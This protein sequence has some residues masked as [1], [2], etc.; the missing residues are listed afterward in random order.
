MR[1]LNLLSFKDT[2]VK[3][4]ILAYSTE[5]LSALSKCH[6]NKTVLTEM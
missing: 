6:S 3:R 5:S 4:S 1:E 2:H